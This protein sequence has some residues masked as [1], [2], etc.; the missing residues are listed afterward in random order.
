MADFVNAIYKN[1]S[2]AD[3]PEPLMKS[4][5]KWGEIIFP[6]LL[7]LTMMSAGLHIYTENAVDGYMILAAAVCAAVFAMCVKL[8]KIR[9]GGLLY[10]A[11]LFIGSF[12]PGILLPD[13]PTRIDFVQ[14]FFSG[15]KAVATRPVFLIIFI[16]FFGFFFC[17]VVFY[18]TQ[19]VY[20]SAV[21]ILISMIPLA[22]AI[23]AAAAIPNAYPIIISALDLVIFIYYSRKKIKG[24]S[25]S[26]SKISSI[27]VYSDFAAAAVLLAM[28]I[29]KPET[30][31]YYERFEEFM[32]RFQFGGSGETVMS[33]DY[34]RYS[35]NADDLLNSESRLLYILST[36]DP[37][38]MKTQVF[39]RYD[40]ENNRWESVGENITGSRSWSDHAALLN[41]EKLADA[42]EKAAEYEPSLYDDYPSIK[43]LDGITETES[44]ATVYTQQFPAVYVIAPLRSTYANVVA[45]G[46][47]YSV[48]SA[49][50]E[51]FTDLPK[52]PASAA[53]TL[54]YYSESIYGSGM[55]ESGL[56]DISS[57]EY[58]ECLRAAEEALYYN[59]RD[60]EAY[61]VVSEFLNEHLNAMEYRQENVTDVSPQ[62][63][64]LSDSITAGLEYDWQKAAAIEQY[65]YTGG[66]IYNLTYAPPEDSDTAEFFLFEGKTGT[67]SDFASA[68]ALLA[69]AA[70]L[71][72]RY[73]EGFIPSDGQN[74][75]Q[76][77]KFIYTENAHAYPEVYI[78][79]AGWVIY[80]PTQ[81]DLTGGDAGN[82]GN[83]S[84]DI[85]TAVFTA[86]IGIICLGIFILFIILRPKIEEGIFRLG[87]RFNGNDPAV[88][89]L[90][91]R[92]AAAMGKKYSVEYVSMTAEELSAVT[93]EK[94]G[95][96]LKPLSVPFSECCYGGKNITDDER[97]NSYECYMA[98]Y[99]EINRR[100]KKRKDR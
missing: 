74:P 50:G 11:V 46:A 81:P 94:T 93:E 69:R 80:E 55:L 98:Q 47:G 42:F 88:K 37:V 27:V 57:E 39:D 87:I 82:D 17:S 23:K 1:V 56:C 91:N 62:I 100:N 33:G 10:F 96:D 89:K 38:Y 63:Q 48:R 59:D 2:E 36:D 52:L 14:W 22:L 60:S 13:W 32:N 70:G 86:I 5:K 7:C 45:T 16:L 19:I 3:L 92:H 34:N 79:G 53:Y 78:P 18:F 76:E 8:R 44:N 15:S 21:V 72:V 90:Y 25:F 99:K 64:E 20:R 51:I 4:I 67:C 75:V 54:K 41:Y 71:T 31:P 84:E 83:T 95:I 61:D 68:Y 65:F 26:G 97:K 29:P 58:E 73:T 35:G 49:A 12:M 6:F 9:F 85:L 24:S 77:T 30:A 28:I 66:F 43:Y 40:A